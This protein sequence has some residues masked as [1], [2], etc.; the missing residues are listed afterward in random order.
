MIKRLSIKQR[1]IY[2]ITFMILLV[3]SLLLFVSNNSVKTIIH[4]AEKKELHNYYDI[5][6][7]QLD[8]TGQLAIGLATL[9]SLNEDIQKDFAQENRE[10]LARRTLPTFK[11]MKADFAARQ[12]QFHKPPAYSFF[13]VHKPEKFGDDLS[14][15][16]KTVIET[17]SS[18]SP[19]MGLEKG[20]AGIGIRGVVPVSYKGEH[21]GSVEFGMSFG[22]PFFEKFKSSY[23]VDIALYIDKKGELA[24]FGST[25]GEMV[26]SDKTLV[27]EI[28]T[29]KTEES[30]YQSTMNDTPRA[31]FL[32]AI[33][34]YSGNPI[35]VL[36]V[37]MDRSRNVEA[38]NSVFMQ[39]I[40][41]GVI[42]L[43]LGSL[44][45][46]IISLGI[47]RP[48]IATAAAMQDIAEGDGDLTKRLEENTGDELGILAQA[49]NKYSSKVHST[50]A[51]A[52]SVSIQ[53][54][55]SSEEL[56][57]ITTESGRNLE[58]QQQETEQVATA[59]NQMLM[60]VQEIAQ[61]AEEASSAANSAD[62]ATI[63]GQSNVEKVVETIQ[64]LAQNITK[65]ETVINKLETQ[66]KDI[67]SVLV[68]IRNI[69][70]QTNL[71]ALNA[72]IEAARA[73]E[74]GRGFAVVADE[75]RTLASKVQGS[76]EE[77]QVMIEALQSGAN[78]AVEAM[79]SSIS[80][81]DASVEVAKVAQTTLSEIAASVTTINDMNMQISSAATEQVSVSD[82]INK[83]IVNI[84]DAVAS[85]KDSGIQI[86]K[87]SDELALLASDMQ[88][89]MNQFKL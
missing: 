52:S 71:L 47:T 44:A 16:R 57:G 28:L 22:Q 5:A 13:R 11:V 46:Y 77:I 42:V 84:S 51:K 12:F 48:I 15:F 88:E 37:V 19:I 75:V 33:N 53:L 69:A 27:R 31:V 89:T 58:M 66:S 32:H 3:T 64:Q 17:N 29:G 23:N 86:S 49:F 34:D 14:S 60:T 72:A 45:A 54:A 10:E 59:M 25:L 62:H 56:A 26:F 21:T 79:Q 2:A 38:I 87:A 6:K 35:G 82:E 40:I 55:G 7:A 43:L 68:V 41:I 70:E 20:V 80:Y 85:S 30:Y 67:D 50:V 73:G 8:S 18:K 74:H 65:A 4:E 78:N 76:T 24:P 83:N 39:F 36:E 61:N 63:E 9:I 81:S 1:V